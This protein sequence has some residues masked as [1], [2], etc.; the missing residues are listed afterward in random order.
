MVNW[1]V[2][3]DL[4]KIKGFDWSSSESLGLIGREPVFHFSIISFNQRTH[5]CGIHKRSSRDEF[6]NE[7]F[8]KSD[9]RSL[10]TDHYL[11][12]LITDRGWQPMPMCLS[13]CTRTLSLCYLGG[14]TDD[15]KS[16]YHYALRSSSGLLCL[17]TIK[18]CLLQQIIS[19]RY[20]I[21]CCAR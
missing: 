12:S 1:K 4:Q 15:Q 14:Q 5:T 3:K 6:S 17:L 18:F 9:G 11:K 7:T 8:M 16:E 13:T 21:F 19:F 10:I 20:V 2:Q